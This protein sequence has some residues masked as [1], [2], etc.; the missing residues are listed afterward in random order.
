MTQVSA[1]TGLYFTVVLLFKVLLL[2]DDVLESLKVE[3]PVLETPFGGPSLSSS[4]SSP[5][6]SSESRS[7]AELTEVL[8]TYSFEV[9]GK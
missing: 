6:R 3:G 1:V 8:N 2:E 9:L 5:S 7:E 4:S